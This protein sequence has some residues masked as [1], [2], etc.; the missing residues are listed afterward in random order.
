MPRRDGLDTNLEM[1]ADFTAS[2]RELYVAAYERETEYGLPLAFEGKPLSHLA[3]RTYGINLTPNKPT[4][5]VTTESLT[6]KPLN[7]ETAHSLPFLAPY[8]IFPE[9]VVEQ[10]VGTATA[11]GTTI[12]NHT[13][14]I[15]SALPAAGVETDY[16]MR[17]LHGHVNYAGTFMQ[18]PV[19]T[20]LAAAKYFVDQA[21]QYVASDKFHIANLATFMRALDEDQESAIGHAF[22]FSIEP[23]LP[24]NGYEGPVFLANFRDEM[25]ARLA[26][27]QKRVAQLEA[28][29]GTTWFVERLQNQAVRLQDAVQRADNML[30]DQA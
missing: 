8:R 28:I 2:A 24:L 30:S 22:Q 5:H 4:G 6:V 29:S 1:L 7:I 27:N 16:R 11:I 19:K 13:L 15:R 17:H 3:L 18:K 26:V 20:N 21:L 25:V 14:D 10:Y 23:D 12:I 9:D